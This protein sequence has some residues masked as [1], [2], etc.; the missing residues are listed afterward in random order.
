M[1]LT[2]IPILPKE[3]KKWLFVEV[4]YKIVGGTHVKKGTYWTCYP[5]MIESDLNDWID[6]Y[7]RDGQWYT[8]E[9]DIINERKGIPSSLIYS[10]ISGY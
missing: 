5:S 1:S 6:T 4:E 8:W 2:G 9:Y 7:G 10:T 3:A